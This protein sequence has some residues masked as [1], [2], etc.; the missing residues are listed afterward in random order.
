MDPRSFSNMDP[1]PILLPDPYEV[2]ADP[3]HCRIYNLFFDIISA[4]GHVTYS[5]STVV[6][7]G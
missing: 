2:I 5:N 4:L 6:L 7:Q 3:K 1:D